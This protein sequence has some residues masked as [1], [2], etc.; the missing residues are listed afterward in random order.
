MAV[1]DLVKQFRAAAWTSSEEAQAFCLEAGT[2]PAA[3]VV[4]LL[5][6]LL[7]PGR[8]DSAAQHNRAIVFSRTFCDTTI[9]I[10]IKE[11]IVQMK[12]SRKGKS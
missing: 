9:N 11:P 8:V 12:T 5:E 3:E 1:K 4:K 2:L 7:N 10:T 6:V